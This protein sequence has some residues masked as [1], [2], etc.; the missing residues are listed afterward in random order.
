MTKK[1]ITVREAIFLATSRT[2]YRIKGIDGD[3]D[4]TLTTDEVREIVRVL[5]ESKSRDLNLDT[6]RVEAR[7]A[8]DF[9]VR[10]GY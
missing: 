3:G 6:A 5:D 4:Y 2:V 1:R 7:R 9:R 8:L 10:N